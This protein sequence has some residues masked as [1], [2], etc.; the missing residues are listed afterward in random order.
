MSKN[1]E[2]SMNGEKYMPSHIKL[3][4]ILDLENVSKTSSALTS[5]SDDGHSI[6]HPN[7][8]DSYTKIKEYVKQQQEKSK[9]SQAPTK[10][11]IYS[12]VLPPEQIIA[13]TVSYDPYEFAHQNGYLPK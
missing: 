4:T 13:S 7:D 11:K 8:L 3:P 10:P 9:K 5:P 1:L 6:P 12:P 2:L